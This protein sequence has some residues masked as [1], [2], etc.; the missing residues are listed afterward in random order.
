MSGCW[1]SIFA[2][3][4]FSGMRPNCNTCLYL[5]QYNLI[6]HNIKTQNIGTKTFD[7]RKIKT[8]FIID[9]DVYSNVTFCLFK[10]YVYFIR[11][12]HIARNTRTRFRY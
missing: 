6:I 4:S 1:F 7:D 11:D 8:G 9:A 5:V 3:L 10:L 2:L 12:M